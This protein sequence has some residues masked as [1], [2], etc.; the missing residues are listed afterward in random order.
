MSGESA[1][2]KQKMAIKSRI[3]R[4]EKSDTSGDGPSMTQIM[5]EAVGLNE[6]VFKMDN[7]KLIKLANDESEPQSTRVQ[8]IRRLLARAIDGK[9]RLGLLTMEQTMTEANLTEAQ[10]RKIT[11]ASRKGRLLQER[12]K[13]AS[14]RVTTH[15][16]EEINKEL[17]TLHE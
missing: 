15:R 13:Q 4:L 14:I 17:I 2:W 11:A 7:Q 16:I 10:E 8:V 9:T 1:N 5:T 6:R 3:E 12:M